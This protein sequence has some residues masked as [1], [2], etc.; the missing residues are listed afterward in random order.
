MAVGDDIQELADHGLAALTASHDYYTHTKAAWRLLEHNVKE[1][2]RFTVRD[3]TTGT[4]ADQQA[5]LGLSQ[6][7]VASYLRSSTFQHF[8]SLFEDF[9]FDLLRLWLAAH[10]GSLAKKKIEF[11]TVLKAP[12]KAAITLAVV[13]RELNELRY[14]RVADWFAYLDKLVHLGCPTADEKERI[15]EIK[16]SRDIL[17][18]N[19]GMVNAVYVVKAG[20]RA[21]YQDGE[22]LEIPEPYHRESWTTITKV[23]REVSG[24]AVQKA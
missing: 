2:R 14:E 11:G 5:L 7:Y 4:V 13:D 3:T 18:H 20:S 8:V 16:A 24:A 12:D 23:I 10:P 6:P 22:R 17:V 9:F 1:G 15:A 19:K 21:R